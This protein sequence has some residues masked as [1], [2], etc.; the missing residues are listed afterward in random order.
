[1]PG[2]DHARNHFGLFHAPLKLDGLTTGFFQ[3]SSGVFDCPEYAQVKTRKRHVD[4][5]Q[6]VAYRSA[7]HFSVIDHLFE[8]DRQRVGVALYDHREAIPDQ[9]TFNAGRI[10]KPG[11]GIV[12]GGEHCDLVPSG[13]HRRELGHLTARCSEIVMLR[14]ANWRTCQD[15]S[16]EGN[17]SRKQSRSPLSWP[18]CRSQ[19]SLWLDGSSQKPLVAIF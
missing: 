10:D 2:R 11:C 5:Q 14:Y 4:N 19:F 7:D 1:M 3:D 12:V 8:R 13:F 18:Y 6:S 16:A 9:N 17:P 15:P